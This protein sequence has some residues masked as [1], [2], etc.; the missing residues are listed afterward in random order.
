MQSERRLWG[1]TEQERAREKG[2][3]LAHRRPQ[4][5]R[6][7][8]QQEQGYLRRSVKRLSKGTSARNRLIDLINQ[9]SV[10]GGVPYKEGS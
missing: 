10:A 7:G 4:E 8:P 9:S 3:L 1:C 5:R 6:G 2:G